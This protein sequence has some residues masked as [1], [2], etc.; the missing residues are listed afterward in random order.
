[1]IEDHSSLVKEHFE[2]EYKEYDQLIRKLI[3][4]YGEMHQLVVD[5]LNFPKETRLKILD[6]GIGTGQTALKILQKFPKANIEG[7]DI[8]GNMI[9]Q[10]KL[11]LKNHLDRVRFI[12]KDIYKSNFTKKYDAV[13]SVLCIHHLNSKQKQDFFD[14]IFKTLNKNGIFIIADIVKFDSEEETKDKE[15][16]WKDFLISNLGEKD[17]NF[18]FQN[19]KEEDLPDSTNNQMKWLENSGFK[20]VKCSFEYMNYSVFYAKK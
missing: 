14:M 11:R 2:K 13:V 12:E 20:E 3:P 16:E 19:Y 18:W 17:G 10:A 4:K 6:L 9:K 1:M 5:L 15:K 7:I 8:S